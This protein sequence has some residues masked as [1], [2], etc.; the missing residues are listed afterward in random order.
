MNSKLTAILVLIFAMCVVAQVDPGTDNITHWYSF[1]DG[2]A[3]DQVGQAHGVVIGEAPIS[4][5]SLHIDSLTQWVELPGDLILAL[6]YDAITVTTWFTPVDS[7]NNGFHMV[8]YFGDS[9]ESGLGSNGFF[10]SPCRGDDVSRAALSCMEEAEPWTAENGVNGPETN[11]GILH[12]MVVTIDDAELTFYVDGESMGTTELLGE[13]AL[14]NISQNYAYIGR[15]GFANDPVFLSSIHDVAIYN[16]VLTAD[17]VLFLYQNFPVSAVDSNVGTLPDNFA[18]AQNYPNPFNPTTTIDFSL[19]KTTM[20]TLSVYNMIGQRVATLANGVYSA[21]THKTLW[22]GTDDTGQPVE[23][24]LY[25]YQLQ[26]EEMT[27]CRKMV[28]LK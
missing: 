13:N 2:T 17:E 1:D 19:P 21:G 14:W 23:S 18:L 11:D 25:M 28:L 12:H 26:T 4:G 10:I 22:D 8:V 16:R 15:G 24:G 3:N 20:A 6:E 9:N 5:G 27:L 7:A